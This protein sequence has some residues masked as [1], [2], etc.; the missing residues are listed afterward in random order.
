MTR[1]P[2]LHAPRKLSLCLI[3]AAW[4]VAAG[5]APA[6]SPRYAITEV[7]AGAFGETATALN[8]HGAV[9]FFSL[10]DG[11]DESI[12]PLGDFTTPGRAWLYSK[13]TGS[14]PLMGLGGNSDAVL[15]LNNSGQAV[16]Q[17]RSTGFSG[18]GAKTGVWTDGVFTPLPN[19]PDGRPPTNA[20]A[21]N[22]AGSIALTEPPRQ[23]C[24]CQC[25]CSEAY[26]YSE[27]NGYASVPSLG[28]SQTRAADLNAAGEL[29]GMTSTSD[30]STD[31][32]YE[33]FIYRDGVTKS[34][35]SLGGRRGGVW[36]INNHS[37]AV[38]FSEDASGASLAFYWN[39]TSGMARL[40]ALTLEATATDINDHGEVVGV[41]YPFGRSD[42]YFRSQAFYY[43]TTIGLV[44]LQD[45]LVADHD[46]DGLDSAIAIN[47]R[48]QILG[49]GRI[50]SEQRIFLASP[51][52]E[53]GSLFLLIVLTGCGT[54]SR[55]RSSPR[56]SVPSGLK[57]EL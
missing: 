37:E 3:A 24:D 4:A 56:F 23:S 47:N 9:A 25:N 55:R 12:P 42:S 31:F 32:T 18:V 5:V 52:P 6:H 11:F 51:V 21:I 22:D 8:D 30:N 57:A 20:V 35:G 15:D 14:S 50:G 54:L 46:W 49:R 1:R 7:S 13:Q 53:P 27:S 19:L 39:E 26:L 10:P 33:P 45:L 43:N 29:V 34:L 38:G 48:G 16:G 40:G 28:G 44:L 2:S 41:D 17:S 36:A